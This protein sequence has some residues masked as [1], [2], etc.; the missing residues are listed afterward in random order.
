MEFMEAHLQLEE[1]SFSPAARYQGSLQYLILAFTQ[2]PSQYL[3]VI[4]SSCWPTV[5][6]GRT[7]LISVLLAQYNYREGSPVMGAND[8]NDTSPQTESS[9]AGNKHDNAINPE[10]AL[11]LL[12]IR[13]DSPSSMAADTEADD[14][15]AAHL[16]NRSAGKMLQAEKFLGTAVQVKRSSSVPMMNGKQTSKPVIDPAKQHRDELIMD[17][18]KSSIV[19]KR[20]VEKLY[21]AGQPEYF[22]YFVNKFKRRSPLIN[23]GYWLRMKAIE[24]GVSRF[25]SERTAKKKIVINLGCGYDPLPWLFL[26]KQPQ[27]C[28]NTVFVDVDYPEL[29]QQK[30]SVIDKTEQLKELLPKFTRTGKES[31]LLASSDPYV[32]IGCDLINLSPLQ[33][34][35]QDH[36][37]A[38]SGSVAI[39]FTS[40]VSTAYMER[41]ASQAV[42]QWAATFDDVRFCLLEQHLPD[43]PDHPFAATMLAHFDKLRT[44]LRAAGTMEDMKARFVSAGFPESGT[45]IRSLWELWSDPTFLSAEERRALDRVEPFDEWEEFALFGSHYFLLVAEKEPNKNYSQTSVHRA[46][47]ASFFAGSSRA[48]MVSSPSSDRPDVPQYHFTASDVV[49]AHEILEPHD[50]RRFTAIIPPAFAESSDGSVGL[51]GG[52]GTQERLSSCNTYSSFEAGHALEPIIGP[53]I[54]NGIMCHAVTKLG[55]T[56]NCVLT[57]GRTSPDKA[58][59]ESWLRLDGKWRRVQDLP[60]GRFRHCAVPLVLPTNPRPAH[61]VLMFGGKTGDGQVLDEWLI[62]TG[63]T[64]WQQVTMKGEEKPAARFGATMITDSREGTSGVLIGGMTSAGRVLNDFWHWNLERDMTLTCRNVTTRAT[65][66]LKAD[67]C[68]LGRF[69]AQL[70]RSPQGILMIGGITGARMLTRQDEILNMKTLRPQPLEGSRP[71]FVGHSVQDVDDSILILGGGA[72]CFSFGT[73]WSRSCLLNRTP[74]DSFQMIWQLQTTQ[75]AGKPTAEQS[76]PFNET[77]KNPNPSTQSLALPIPTPIPE[78]TLTSTTSFPTIISASRPIIFKSCDLGRCTSLWTTPYL[79]SAV[80]ATRPV[81]IHSPTTPSTSTL[82]FASKNFTYTTLPFGDFLD[83]I[84][85]GQHLYLRSL[86]STSPSTLPTHL[87]TDFPALAPDFTL[88]P[89]LSLAMDSA[90]SSP[91][92]ISGPVN[93]WLHFDIHANLLCQIRGTKRLLL[94]P[95]SDVSHLGFPPSASSSPIDVFAADPPASLAATTPYEAILHPGDVLFIPPMWPHTAQ[96]LTDTSVAVNVFFRN[97]MEKG[98]AAGKDVYG[99]RDLAAYEKGRKDLAK[100]IKAF[101]GLPAEVAGFYLERLGTELVE[102]GQGLMR[103]SAIGGGGGAAVGGASISGPLSDGGNGSAGQNGGGGGE[104]LHHTYAELG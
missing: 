45:D 12:G 103:S 97:L 52:M 27:L 88:P 11:R 35:L 22:R 95:P 14:M 90:H 50:Y 69:G 38:G 8:R 3:N 42:F 67:A 31:G 93:I 89:Q 78:Q 82:S 86:S 55:S 77:P 13:T 94:F 91:L 2:Q 17:T 98:Y 41:E 9:H 76:K 6:S 73:S 72:T 104:N 63:E 85:A 20:S 47:R 23:R 80:G 92:R 74:P 49:D 19:S 29:M 16:D 68:I 101:D 57:G 7:N 51:H 24:Y 59:A 40:E 30:L 60:T 87:A 26:G 66:F 39:L 65:A 33:E 18:N 48:S 56:S 46:S 44:P 62:W 75:E 53:P 81:S 102:K 64:G 15:D 100:I 37:Q 28:Q 54:R 21:Y 99:N 43:G 71:L 70:V 32:A 34:I 10:K 4:N 96:P 25:L 79:K 36:L 84:D 1:K 58:S 61:T 83:A 5:Y